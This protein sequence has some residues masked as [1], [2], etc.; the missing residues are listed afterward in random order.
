MSVNVA[1]Q[2]RKLL[3]DIAA[4]EDGFDR[5]T[6]IIEQAL[7]RELHTPRGRFE[8]ARLNLLSNLIAAGRLEIKIAF[9][10]KDSHICQGIDRPA[11]N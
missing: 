3:E 10:E 1:N 6:Q 2:Y 9:L 8:E 4:I 5:R 7:L 11:I